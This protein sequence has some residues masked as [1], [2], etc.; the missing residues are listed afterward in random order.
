MARRI[1]LKE[2]DA[3]TLVPQGY[4]SL[5]NQG[6]D[7]KTADSKG[8]KP[9]SSSGE[10][11]IAKG[12]VYEGELVYLNLDGTV[13]VPGNITDDDN[14]ADNIIGIFLSDAEDSEQVS[15]ITKGIISLDT[16]SLIPRTIYYIDTNGKL[17][18][19]VTPYVL[20]KSLSTNNIM[21]D[22]NFVQSILN[23]YGVVP[24]FDRLNITSVE[25]GIE[26]FWSSEDQINLLEI[27]DYDYKLDFSGSPLSA[28]ASISFRDFIS[29]SGVENGEYLRGII[30][31]VDGKSA[32]FKF[33][34]RGGDGIKLIARYEGLGKQYDVKDESGVFKDINYFSSVNVEFILYSDNKW[35]FGKSN[36]LPLRKM[37]GVDGVQKDESGL[38]VN[39]VIYSEVYDEFVSYKL[40]ESGTYSISISTKSI[41]TKLFTIQEYKNETL[42]IYKGDY[43]SNQENTVLL[44]EIQANT[45]SMDPKNP[46]LSRKEITNTE[47]TTKD[48]YSWV[49]FDEKGNSIRGRNFTETPIEK[50]ERGVTYIYIGEAS[51]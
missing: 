35:I 30:Y 3:S 13:S 26:I 50:I 39:C 10:K 40:Y 49:I 48:I 41:L 32:E 22:I 47:I 38:Y 21:I 34:I 12:D 23:R 11:F 33:Q 19:T 37:F 25:E 44:L 2:N 7:L 20:G 46:T 18:T 16:L 36:I 17:T 24:T 28:T 8:I 27:P 4:V 14:K 15:V 29:E 43:K 9:V 6:G 5:S 42:R 1:F 31:N 45:I 51:V